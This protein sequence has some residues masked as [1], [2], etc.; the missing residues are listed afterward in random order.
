MSRPQTRS[1]PGDTA[2]LRAA[3]LETSRAVL[4]LQREADER[5]SRVQQELARQLA[6]T[7]RARQALQLLLE[8]Q[9]RVEAEL[10]TAE[11]RY[12]ILFDSAPDPVFLVD[13]DPDALGRILDVNELGASLHGY[14]REELLAMSISELDTPD[15][16]RHVPERMRRLLAGEALRFEVSHRRKDGSEF[17]IEVTARRTEIDGRPCILSYNR[18]ITERKRVEAAMRETETRWRFALDGAGDGLWDWNVETGAVYYS[19][20]WKSMLGYAET[21]LGD[22][23]QVW[24]DLVHP[25]DLPA[26]SVAVAE[27]FTG[28][29]KITYLEHR[30]RCSDGSW[31]W[32]LARGQVVEWIGP[33]RPRRMIGT[34]TDID[35]AKRQEAVQQTLLRR[36]DLV[37]RASRIG[38]WEW[39]LARQNL[40]WDD[41][42][43]A[44]YG[45][46]R[47]ESRGTL[48]DFRSCVHPDDLELVD[49]TFAA[50]VAGDDI[51]R[52]EFRIV[53]RSDRAI[54]VIE[55]NGHL[56]RDADGKPERLLGMNRDI[57]EEKQAEAARRSLEEQLVQAQKMETLGTLAGGIAHDFNNILTG[58]IGCVELAGQQMQDR[59]DALDLLAR[60]RGAGMRARDL[61]KRLMLFA[62]RAP[63][64]GRNSLSLGRMLDE[65][66][67]ILVATLPS[68]IVLRCQKETGADEIFGDHG[69]IQQVVLNLCLNAADAIGPKQG[70]IEIELRPV[71]I[72]PDDGLACAPGPAL[73]LSISDD[74]CGMDPAT[75]ARVFDPFFTT[76]PEGKGTGL[77]LAIVHGI[78][79]DHGGAIRLQSAP[80]AGCRFDIFL[81]RYYASEPAGEDVSPASTP[82]I[83]GAGRRVLLADDEEFVRCFAERILTGCGFVVD[84]ANDGVEGARRFAAA[85]AAYALALVDLSMPGRNGFELIGDL[86][87]L[88]PDLP[89]ILMSG[90]HHRYDHTVGAADHPEFLELSKPFGIEELKSAIRRALAATATT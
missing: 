73:R 88:R 68:S 80:G 2:K 82:E 3:A 59:P 60:A 55:G 20:R 21:D 58:I 81:P 4:I 66:L 25:D 33:G 12:R 5:E 27:H 64:T 74:G 79:H 35:Q 15:S 87:R 62:R 52:F 7:N 84:T 53:R 83:V 37:M 63:D 19:R 8:E 43:H 41:A 16:A 70:H 36:L 50:L 57:T 1:E 71:E 11:Q 46:T 39:D 30:M 40:D 61:V 29:T 9:R 26:A 22:T 42:M 34:H 56:L 72:L 23:I 38:V 28:A 47:A 65:T 76:K 18:D 48:P 67:P 17:P 24:R 49:R 75:Q 54:R 85:P 77:G 32:I 13:G 86:R 6:E 31:K 51:H 14:T 44:L 10:R 69:Q 90:D 78:V 45:V 89:A